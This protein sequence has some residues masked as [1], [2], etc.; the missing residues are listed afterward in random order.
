MRVLLDTNIVSVMLRGKEPPRLIEMMA[1]IAQEDTFICVTTA[2]EVLYGLRRRSGLELIEDAFEHLVQRAGV[3]LPFD[4]EAARICADLTITLEA[5]GTPLDLADL[6]IA[7][8]ALANSLALITGNDR[9]FRR[10]PGLR[11]YNWL[12]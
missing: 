8:I 4:L 2:R 3:V 10:I 9:H 7:S 12:D 11:V 1:E 5:Q 6:E